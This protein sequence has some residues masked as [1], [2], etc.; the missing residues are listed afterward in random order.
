MHSALFGFNFVGDGVTKAELIQ[1]WNGKQKQHRRHS[2]QELLSAFP[3]LPEIK[4]HGKVKTHAVQ[5]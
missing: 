2:C 1:A 4:K 3:T 5:R